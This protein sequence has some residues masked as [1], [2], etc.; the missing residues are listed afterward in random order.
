ME[1]IS[2]I[3]PVYNAEKY[4]NSCMNSVVSQ[5]F[6]NLE[7]ILVDDGSSD[8]SPQICDEWAQ[9]DAR[10]R[11][12]HRLNRGAA[13]ARNEGIEM[14]TGSFLTFVDADDLLGIDTLHYAYE[15]QQKYQADLVI[16]NFQFVNE[17]GNLLKEPDFSH[18]PNEV[19]G[20]NE[21]WQRYFSLGEQSIYYVVVWNKLYKATLFQTLRFPEGKLYEDQFYMPGLY[22]QCKVIVC[23]SYVGYYYIQWGD[24]TMARQGSSRN[25]LDRSE[26]LI[27]WC[28]YF[29]GKGDFLRAEGLL[30]DAIQNL[31]EKDRFDLSTPEQQARYRADCRACADAYADL[32]RRTGQRTMWLRAALLCMG[33]PV[34]RKFLQSKNR[35]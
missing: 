1:K 21:V 23:L 20:E 34:Y 13:A 2:V 7:I 28:G 4:L 18:M 15:V 33:L 8:R 10:V 35:R 30:N 6:K 26:F 31:S 5:T 27:E 22:K 16:Y 29:A 14:A 12:I 11:V 17:Q 3:I 25:Y 19:L 32:A 9:K 24:S